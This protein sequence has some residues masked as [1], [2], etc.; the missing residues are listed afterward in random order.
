DT[1]KETTSPHFMNEAE[2]NEI[3]KWV[4][5]GGV[6]VLL[7]NDA[8]NC[9]IAKFNTLSQKFGITFNED[10]RNM[11]KGSNYADGAVVIPSKTG[12]FK[13]TQKIYVKEIST[14]NAVKLAKPL[15]QDRKSVV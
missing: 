4:R 1:E 10:N 9:E 6:L 7:A 5:G 15:V 11:V 14:I 2:A 8:G 13:K 3:A 12:I